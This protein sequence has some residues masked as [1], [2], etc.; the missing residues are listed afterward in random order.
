MASKLDA[1]SYVYVYIDPRNF[2]EFY[3]GKGRG[4]RSHAH[5]KSTGDSAKAS[6]IAQIKK[7]GLEPVIRIVAASLTS[8]EAHLIETAFLWKL[9][10]NLANETSGHFASK[11]R[12]QYSMYQKLGGF[13]YSRQI[14]YLNVGEGEVRNWDDC[15]KYGFMAAGQHEKY[16]RQ[17]RQL[18]QGDCIAAYLKGKGYVGV[19]I[20]ESEAVPITQ[21]SFGTKKLLTLKLAANMASNANDASK[22]EHVVKIDW[23]KSVPRESAIFKRRSK[24][25]A[26]QRVRASLDGQTKTLK[27]IEDEWD[28]SFDDILA[29]D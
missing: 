16:S 15:R 23:I 1:D 12:P 3:Y 28:L 13:D 26:P 21:F 10:R 8:D 7:A 14:H 25:F 4:S 24:L 18:N 9:G 22:C 6:R 17:L 27:F 29:D 5:L 19:G 11:F 2:E 20:V